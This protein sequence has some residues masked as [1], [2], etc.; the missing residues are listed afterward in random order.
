MK[1]SRSC[2][3]SVEEK[4]VEERIAFLEE[5][6]RDIVKQLGKMTK[7]LEQLSWGRKV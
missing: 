2:E 1:T 6:V 5:M 3:D 7:V 4:T